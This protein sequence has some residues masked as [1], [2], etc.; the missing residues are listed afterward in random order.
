MQ[1]QYKDYY[2]ASDEPQ[3]VEIS[4]ASYISILGSGSPGTDIFYAKKKAIA[5][6]AEALKK[7]FADTDNAFSDNIIEIFYWFDENKVGY[8]DIG[9]FY[10]TV[11]LALLQYRIA[12]RI[13]DFISDEHIRQVAAR[14]QGIPF[15]NSFEHFE[16]TEGTCVQLLHSGPFAGELETLPILQQFATANGLKK[17]GMHHEIHLVNFE[18]GQSQ[19]HLQTILRDAVSK[20]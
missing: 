8:V 13:R 20:I 1:Q 12:I 10:T 4:K 16:Y 6:F 3:I 14:R 7:D 18:K 11:D 2:T 15:A 19:A 5:S 17:S 9:N